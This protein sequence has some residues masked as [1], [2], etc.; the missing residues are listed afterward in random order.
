MAGLAVHPG[1]GLAQ[2]KLRVA[3]M[4]KLI[5]RPLIDGRMAAFALRLAVLDELA[6]V[7]I[8][9]ARGACGGRCCI[10][11]DSVPVSPPRMAFAAARLRMSLPLEEGAHIPV[12]VGLDPE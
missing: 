7:N 2:V 11:D 4:I 8:L 10:L 3:L 6:A 5:C 9:M 1:M 12:G